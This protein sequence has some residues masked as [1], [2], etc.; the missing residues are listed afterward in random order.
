MYKI[1]VKMIGGGNWL[2]YKT[3]FHSEGAA[4][5]YARD[6]GWYERN[7]IIRVVRWFV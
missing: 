1:Q 4:K 5:E 6:K 3:P 7:V 2:T